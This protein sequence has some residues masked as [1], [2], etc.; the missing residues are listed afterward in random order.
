M[1]RWG[2][3]PWRVTRCCSASLVRQVDKWGQNVN[4]PYPEWAK[5]VYSSSENFGRF[6]GNLHHSVMEYLEA[7][8]LSHGINPP[9]LLYGFRTILY[10]II[11]WKGSRKR[12][13]ELRVE[14]MKQATLHTFPLLYAVAELSPSRFLSNRMNWVVLSEDDPQQNALVFGTDF[15]VELFRAFLIVIFKEK[16]FLLHIVLLH[17][18]VCDASMWI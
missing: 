5:L 8:L 17:I 7:H 9:V 12:V 1:N 10:F 18:D 14:F 16:D 6:S 13:T 11:L 15:K 4:S 3:L 2:Q